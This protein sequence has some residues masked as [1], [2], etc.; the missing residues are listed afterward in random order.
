MGYEYFLDQ[1]LRVFDSALV[2]GPRHAAMLAEAKKAHG[3]DLVPKQGWVEVGWPKSDTYFS[4]DL[5]RSN[6]PNSVNQTAISKPVALLAA[7]WQSRAVID[8]VLR[9]GI[10][11]DWNV[12]VKFPPLTSFFAEPSSPWRETL[13]R[14]E[15]ELQMAFDLASD[16]SS[17]IVLDPE[18]D[19]YQCIAAADVI[20]SNGSS[21]S[22][23][24]NLVGKPA[25]NVITWGHPAGPEGKDLEFSNLSGPG[26]F[27]CEEAAI[28]DVLNRL[29]SEQFLF[30]GPSDILPIVENSTKGIAAR[31]T[32]DLIEESLLGKVHKN[33]RG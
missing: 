7:T 29:K 11:S 24:A 31:L 4:S 3:A 10:T 27:Q 2:P 32:V 9:A 16:S 6:R 20:I 28:G 17:L 13:E 23:E 30:E 19:I 18:A 15:K 33:F 22:L 26:I 21:V 25:L 14:W 8:S 12:M 5:L 1:T